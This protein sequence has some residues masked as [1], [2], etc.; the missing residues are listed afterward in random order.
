MPEDYDHDEGIIW[1]KGIHETC[2][3]MA[4]VE[5]RDY[6]MQG[7]SIFCFADH[8]KAEQFYGALELGIGINVA[9]FEALDRL[10]E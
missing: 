4:F 6:I 7:M 8:G 9:L 1:L 3:M 2:E 5:G 10:D